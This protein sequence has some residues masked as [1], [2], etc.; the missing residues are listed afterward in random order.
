MRFFQISIIPIINVFFGNMLARAGNSF[1]YCDYVIFT[2][3]R[4]LIFCILFFVDNIMWPSAV[5]LNNKHKNAN[6]MSIA[7]FFYQQWSGIYLSHNLRTLMM[8]I[9]EAWPAAVCIQRS[10]FYV[11]FAMYFKRCVALNYAKLKIFFAII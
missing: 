9:E 2:R 3:L 11:H 10:S 6:R 4:S 8:N 1:I 7:L 5:N